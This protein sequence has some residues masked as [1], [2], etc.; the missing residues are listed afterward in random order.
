MSYKL[1]KVTDANGTI[2]LLNGSKAGLGM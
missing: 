2:T 1:E